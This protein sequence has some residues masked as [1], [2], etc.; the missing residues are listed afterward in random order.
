M[1]CGKR[2]NRVDPLTLTPVL[3]DIS[4]APKSRP[5]S[6]HRGRPASEQIQDEAMEVDEYD[7]FNLKLME[8]DGSGWNIFETC[9]MI[10]DILIILMSRCCDT[11]GVSFDVSSKR[12]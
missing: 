8:V 6:N 9:W 4:V 2:H 7:E 3:D 11:L 10:F 5:S 12:C 1:C